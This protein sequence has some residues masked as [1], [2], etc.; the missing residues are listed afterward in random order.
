M[1]T[2]PFQTAF[3]KHRKC[4]VDTGSISMTDPSFADECD[5]NILM[6]QY[7][8]S[9]LIPHVTRYQGQY[10]DFADAPDY[11]TAQIII[12]EANEAFMSLPAH[13]RTKFDNDPAAFLDFVHNPDNKEEMRNLG[14]LN[15]EIELKLNSEA[16]PILPPVDASIEA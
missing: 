13:I 1:A 5:I 7:R 9:E 12:L 6:A 14:L 8:S 15:P 4:D 10:G 16:K 3:G 2:I 11:L